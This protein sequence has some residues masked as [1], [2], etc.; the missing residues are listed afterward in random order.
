MLF[1]FLNDNKIEIEAY[2]LDVLFRREKKKHFKHEYV[3]FVLS[4][5][6]SFREEP[7]ALTH[8]QIKSRQARESTNWQISLFLLCGYFF[9]FAF[10]ILPLCCEFWWQIYDIDLFNKSHSAIRIH[11]YARFQFKLKWMNKFTYLTLFPNL[12]GFRVSL[13]RHISTYWHCEYSG[14]INSWLNFSQ[15]TG[16]AHIVVM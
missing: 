12:Y 13:N 11:S 16:V 10:F 5:L 6:F 4:V 3:D 1:L 7:H 2:T 8:K 15:C 9:R 14:A